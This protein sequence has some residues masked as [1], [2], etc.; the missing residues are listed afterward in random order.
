MAVMVKAVLAMVECLRL[1][2]GR[3][4]AL[5]GGTLVTPGC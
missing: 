4:D 1:I 5:I 2:A 3:A